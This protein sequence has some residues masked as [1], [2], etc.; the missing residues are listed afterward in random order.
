LELS[1][2]DVQLVDALGLTKLTGIRSLPCLGFHE[3][4]FM[5]TFYFDMKDGVPI[6]DRVG[7]QFPTAAGAIE[8]SKELARRF[9]HEHPLK[10]SDLAIV[11]IDES[12]SEVHRQQVYPNVRGPE[13]A[14]TLSNSR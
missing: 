4:R 13:V 11:V 3:D 10:D 12:G 2:L 8:H 7:L 9:S 6:R 1:P 14:I 5:R